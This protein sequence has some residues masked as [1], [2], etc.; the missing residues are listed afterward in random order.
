[1][2]QP[3][4]QEPSDPEASA[5]GEAEGTAGTDA[6]AGTAGTAAEQSFRKR[7]LHLP[8]RRRTRWLALGAAVVV[9]GGAAAVVAVHHGE[10]G[11]GERFGYA[12]ADGR[13]GHGFG[14]GAA[15]RDIARR[16]NG[17]MPQLKGG[18]LGPD[19]IPFGGKGGPFGGRTHRAYV[20]PAPLPAL[21]AGQ[22][23]EKATAAVP[24][25]KV[26]ELQVVDQQGG[27]SAWQLDVLGPDGVRHLV[28]VDGTN[29]TVTSNTIAS[30]ETPA[31]R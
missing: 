21:S 25:G 15:K 14:P 24:G 17:M 31:G 20:A 12:F 9:L 18:P 28:T 29:G 8:R 11:R 30:G 23:V 4:A 5:A 13:G 3:Y 1:M 26:D 27:G 19:G 7:Y 10:N 16:M 22:A 2:S 6:T